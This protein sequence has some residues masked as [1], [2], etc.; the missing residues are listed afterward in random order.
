MNKKAQKKLGVCASKTHRT[1][2]QQTAF[3]KIL[4]NT[5]QIK[6][7]Y[8]SYS[9]RILSWSQTELKWSSVIFIN[10]DNKVMCASL[11]SSSSFTFH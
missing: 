6:P 2:E 4:N 9:S 10:N 5:L 7:N 1:Y 11:L 8:S 3:H